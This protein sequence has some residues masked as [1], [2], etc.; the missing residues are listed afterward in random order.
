MLQP[1]DHAGRRAG[2]AMRRS[3]TTARVATIA[4]L[5][6][7]DTSSLATP[8]LCAPRRVERAWIDYNGHMNMAYYNLVFDQALDQVFDELGIGAAYVKAGHGSCFTVEIHVTYVQELKLDDPLRVTFQLLD[9]D[10]AAA[11]LREMYHAED[12]YLAATSEQ[13]RCTSTWRPQ[14]GPLP[15]QAQQR[16]ATLMQQHR[17][18]AT[19]DQVGRDEDSRA[20]RSGPGNQ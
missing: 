15:A 18:L 19:S 10:E 20:A 7:T 11:F 16:I 1:I 2:V 5:F 14:A 12:G 9:W 3:P 8:Y 13:C 17:R 6:V 4:R